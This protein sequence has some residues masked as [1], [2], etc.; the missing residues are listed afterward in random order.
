MIKCDSVISVIDTPV[1]VS[2]F[3]IASEI[4]FF[5]EDFALEKV[6]SAKLDFQEMCTFLHLVE[7]IAS[8]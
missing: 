2:R 5:R 8:L 7:N 3:R 1:S 6:E 4:E